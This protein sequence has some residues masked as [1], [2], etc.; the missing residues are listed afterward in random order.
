MNQTNIAQLNIP[1]EIEGYS[2]QPYWIFKMKINGR[3]IRRSEIGLFCAIRSFCEAKSNNAM[4]ACNLSYDGF[5]R[6]YGY[7]HATVARAVKNGKEAGIIG[8][9]KENRSHSAYTFDYLPSTPGKGY[10]TRYNYLK[11]ITFTINGKEGCRLTE[12]QINVLSLIKSFCD[13]PDNRNYEGSM[14]IMQKTLE[15]SKNTIQKAIDVLLAARL[16]F[17]PH[18][19]KNKYNRSEYVVNTRLLRAEEKKYKKSVKN[20]N[21][22]K[23]KKVVDDEQDRRADRERYYAGLR[24]MA[25]ERANRFQCELNSD[26]KYKTLKSRLPKPSVLYRLEYEDGCEYE[27]MKATEK[28]LNVQMAKRRKELGISLADLT[29][30]YHCKH[31]SDKG[32]LPDGKYCDCFPDARGK[33]K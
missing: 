28:S 32:F 18:R 17:R 2:R 16:I 8:Q 19:G 25:E 6:L 29:P 7:S 33:R 4:K 15:C 23:S 3:K 31:C 21:A 24:Q 12:C 5:S 20:F 11:F 1:E 22:P 10:I 9:N 13:D 14:R 27:K 26:E 30:Q